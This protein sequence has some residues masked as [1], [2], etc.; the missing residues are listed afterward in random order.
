[1]AALFTPRAHL[2]PSPALLPLPSATYL[3]E[4]T[5]FT[6]KSVHRTRS[7]ILRTRTCDILDYCNDPDHA[8]E[9]ENV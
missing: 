5:R 6:F 4:E 2:L 1:M 8:S 9:P 3:K 7:L